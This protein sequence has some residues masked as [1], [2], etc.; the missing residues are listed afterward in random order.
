MARAQPDGL[1][2]A[3]AARR[4]SLHGGNR[5]V[6]PKSSVPS[7]PTWA[8]AGPAARP[9][10][11]AT[12]PASTQLASRA[13]SI[14]MDSQERG[15]AQMPAG[16]E[17]GQSIYSGGR[18]H[19]CSAT[20]MMLGYLFMGGWKV[21]R[22]VCLPPSSWGTQGAEVLAKCTHCVQY[23]AP[24]LARD[25]SSDPRPSVHQSSRHQCA[26]AACGCGSEP[27]VRAAGRQVSSGRSP[28][29]RRWEGPPPWC[30]LWESFLGGSLHRSAL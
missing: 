8:Q 7:T 28:G 18:M 16:R 25:R 27:T 10:H 30:G 26:L 1:A 24:V 17:G 9:K 6:S 5:R 12:G 20:R 15:S 21:L 14:H 23:R 29:L 22:C 13:V 2:S 4:L 19:G 11:W 3:H